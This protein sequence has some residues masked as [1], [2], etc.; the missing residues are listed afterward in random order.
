MAERVETGSLTADETAVLEIHRRF[1]SFIVP[2]MLSTRVLT[3]ELRHKNPNLTHEAAEMIVY[4]ATASLIDRELLV[5]G[6]LSPEPIYIAIK[7][8]PM[9]PELSRSA[10][11]VLRVLNLKRPKREVGLAH[12]ALIAGVRALKR[13]QGGQVGEL[14]G[15]YAAVES[16][17]RELKKLGIVVE[18]T[19]SEIGPKG[20][21]KDRYISIPGLGRRVWSVFGDELEATRAHLT[22]GEIEARIFGVGGVSHKYASRV[23]EEGL[24]QLLSR[25]LVYKGND[26]RYSRFT[27]FRFYYD[28][29]NSSLQQLEWA[30][31]QL[32]QVAEYWEFKHPSPFLSPQLNNSRLDQLAK[33]PSRPKLMRE[34]QA[35]RMS[36]LHKLEFFAWTYERLREDVLRRVFN[37]DHSLADLTRVQSKEWEAAVANVVTYG[38]TIGGVIG[39]KERNWVYR[40]VREIH[41]TT[42][43]LGLTKSGENRMPTRPVRRARELAIWGAS[44]PRSDGLLAKHTKG[45]WMNLIVSRRHSN[46]RRQG[47]GMSARPTK[48]LNRGPRHDVHEVRRRGDPRK[49]PL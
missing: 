2:R 28:H 23:T 17:L 44:W 29:A 45:P 38:G 31:R 22:F 10:S 14:S 13:E 12:S 32:K 48:A 18:K 49:E 40:K 36:L 21:H 25:G 11:E 5:T 24:K 33:D 7:D 37:I 30:L 42:S 8:R 41:E 20:L 16:G 47:S 46:R 43:R 27:Y 26:D 1:D 34:L 6:S 9:E 4:E 3:H 39:F 19:E 35:D 15:T